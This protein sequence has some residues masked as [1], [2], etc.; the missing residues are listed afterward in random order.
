MVIITARVSTVI[1]HAQGAGGWTRAIGLPT[2]QP[3]GYGILLII[4]LYL[5]AT[6]VIVQATEQ[7]DQLVDE[8][9]SAEEGT[10]G[11]LFGAG[12]SM[13]G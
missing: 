11:H 4:I 12:Q 10:G 3:A 7:P 13:N 9:R 6:A 2:V 8:G 1:V 5:T